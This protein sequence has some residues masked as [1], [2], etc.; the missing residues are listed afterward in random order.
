M[1]DALLSAAH[2][3]AG[4]E[5]GL[6]SLSDEIF[7]GGD[8]SEDGADHR[9]IAVLAAVAM[10]CLIVGALFWWQRQAA[11]QLS[12]R[13]TTGNVVVPHL[14]GLTVDEAVHKLRVRGLRPG[15]KHRE[16]NATVAPGRVIRTQPAAGA[17]VAESEIVD[18]VVAGGAVSDRAPRV[19]VPRLVGLTVDQAR[20]ALSRRSLELGAI[21]ERDA[22]NTAGTV[23]STSP[24]GGVAV[25]AGS[26]V[27]LI[28]A[29]G[30]SMVPDVRGLTADEARR[31]VKASGFVPVVPFAAAKRPPNLQ[32]LTVRATRPEFGTRAR[33]RTPVVLL[34]PREPAP[35][36]TRSTSQPTPPPTPSPSETTTPPTTPTPSRTPT[37]PPPT[38]T[39]TPTATPTPTETQDPDP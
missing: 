37:Q 32:Q 25:R 34:I 11:P 38:P 22:S 5:R 35:N 10:L 18:L 4:E 2:Q 16:M 13:A 1:R 7:Q 12:D 8:P 27:V 29:S 39:E 21:V 26:E 31:R 30:W 19:E 17:R 28:A 15:Q 3:L 9:P 14:A 24:A 33:L 6:L 23:L 20:R 36:P